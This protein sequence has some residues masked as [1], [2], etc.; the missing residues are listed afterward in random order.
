MRG[1]IQKSGDWNEMG[2]NSFKMAPRR[3]KEMKNLTGVEAHRE[4][5]GGYRAPK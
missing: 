2:L 5:A 4:A 1:I 3:E